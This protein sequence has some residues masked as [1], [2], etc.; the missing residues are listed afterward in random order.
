MSTINDNN[1]FVFVVVLTNFSMRNVDIN[2]AMDGSKMTPKC[3]IEIFNKVFTFLFDELHVSRVT[4]LSRK[5]NLKA[6]K[7]IE[8]FGFVLE[9][10]NHKW[11]RG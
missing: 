8:K 7:I 10:K 5:D 11:Y 4:G 1:D 3:T 9:Y 2:I 6:Q